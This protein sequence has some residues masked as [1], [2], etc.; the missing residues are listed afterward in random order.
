MHPRLDA[1]PPPQRRLWTE[2]R[3]T[4]RRFVLYGGTAIALR[5]APRITWML[6]H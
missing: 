5:L 3:A 2:L 4:P 1:L 6:T